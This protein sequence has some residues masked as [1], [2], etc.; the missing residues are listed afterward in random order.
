MILYIALVSLSTTEQPWSHIHM[1][2]SLL[3]NCDPWVCFK[4]QMFIS[5][6]NQFLLLF[7]LHISWGFVKFY[8]IIP[9]IIVLFFVNF[10]C[11][12]K[13]ERF[14]SILKILISISLLGLNLLDYAIVEDNEFSLV[15]KQQNLECWHFAVI[16]RRDSKC[17]FTFRKKFCICKFKFE[18]I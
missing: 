12:L 7:L 10:I 13:L 11:D 4:V 16:N 2:T 1:G 6:L 9:I 15:I 14:Y 3:V 5:I 17:V 18:H 8:L